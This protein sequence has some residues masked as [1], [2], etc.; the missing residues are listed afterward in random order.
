MEKENR[1][2]K[3]Q[4][5]ELQ[6][7]EEKLDFLRTRF[8]T[9]T[10]PLVDPEHAE[11]VFGGDLFIGTISPPDKEKLTNSLGINID[12]QPN[13]GLAGQFEFDAWLVPESF[14]PLYLLKREIEG[15]IEILAFEETLLEIFEEAE[16]LERVSKT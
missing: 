5:R 4:S 7:L 15:E 10:M 9:R 6:S 14:P 11:V 1:K 16:S 2:E 13:F 8:I 12:E 3:L